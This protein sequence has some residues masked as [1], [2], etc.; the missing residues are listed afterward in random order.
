MPPNQEAKSKEIMVDVD[1][2]SVEKDE[3]ETSPTIDSSTID[4]TFAKASSHKQDL[5]KQVNHGL[6]EC[7]KELYSENLELKEALEKA[8]QLITADNMV[9]ISSLSTSPSSTAS[10]DYNHAVDDIL[11]VEFPL[12]FRDVQEY[13]ALSSREI[14]DGSSKVWFSCKIDKKNGHV[15]SAKTGRIDQQPRDS[16]N[17]VD[18]KNE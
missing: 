18:M 10:T 17:R 3:L 6:K 9:S 4:S 13:V 8:G 7:C 1:G 11:E 2:R 5:S 15:I 12:L 16:N 14:D